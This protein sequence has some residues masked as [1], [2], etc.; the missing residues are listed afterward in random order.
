[1]TSFTLRYSRSQRFVS[2]AC[3][4]TS[5]WSISFVS[6]S[7]ARHSPSLPPRHIPKN[8]CAYRPKSYR[9]RPHTSPRDYNPRGCVYAYVNVPWSFGIRS[10]CRITLDTARAQ[11]KVKKNGFQSSVSL[12]RHHWK[13]DI[14]ILIASH[15]RTLVKFSFVSSS[16]FR[17]PVMH[18]FSLVILLVKQVSLLIIYYSSLLL[19]QSHLS[20]F[21]I[22][23]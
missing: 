22:H 23:Q 9:R 1:M 13:T 11:K 8:S 2:L 5:F 3:S 19:S 16:S 17:Q 6:H 12:P 7:R 20:F 4:L 18:R 21:G 15:P 14:L 10:K